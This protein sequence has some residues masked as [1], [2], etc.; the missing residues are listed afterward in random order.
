MT[1][2]FAS[3]AAFNIGHD[4]DWITKNKRADVINKF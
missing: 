2:Y 4:H 3:F 1:A